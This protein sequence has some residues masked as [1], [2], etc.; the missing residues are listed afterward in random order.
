MLLWSSRETLLR[1]YG[2]FLVVNDASP[3]ADA[4]VV[5]AGIPLDRLPHAFDL[6][7]AGY[8]DNLLVT[9][10]KSRQGELHEYVLDEL[11]FARMVI[12]DQGLGIPVEAVPSRDGETTSTLDEAYD[13]RVYAEAEGLRH[14]IA[15]TSACSSRRAR[16]ALSRAFSDSEIVIQVSPAANEIFDSSNWWKSDKGIQ[17][18]VMEPIK[19]AAYL[20]EYADPD[21]MRND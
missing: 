16:F 14:V 1:A 2:D 8:A 3:G 12:R 11:Q 17:C 15:I 19:L 6:I 9:S 4:V 13:L 21:W 18:Y 20:L 10:P 7:A 5:L